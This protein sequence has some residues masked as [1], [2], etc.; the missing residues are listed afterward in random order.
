MLYLSDLMGIYKKKKK[1]ICKRG[2]D[3]SNLLVFSF[4]S[5]FPLHTHTII[6]Y[7][8]YT[9]SLHDV[10]SNAEIRFIIYNIFD[11]FL[12]LKFGNSSSRK[13]KLHVYMYTYI[14]GEPVSRG[15]TQMTVIV[16]V[17]AG[18]AVGK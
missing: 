12:V 16:T 1:N 18:S 8:S 11:L 14:A 7:F 2:Q 5:L 13:K 17:Y 6:Y 3:T 9:K 10:R 4:C 15:C